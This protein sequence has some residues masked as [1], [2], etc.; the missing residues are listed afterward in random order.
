MSRGADG[1]DD[2]IGYEVEDDGTDECFFFDAKTA[3]EEEDVSKGGGGMSRNSGHGGGLSNSRHSS[4]GGG[5][6]GLSLSRHSSH[7]SDHPHH[8]AEDDEETAATADPDEEHHPDDSFSNDDNYPFSVGDVTCWKAV[9]APHDVF[10]LT[11]GW[12]R[13]NKSQIL[14]GLTVALAQIPEAVS[15]SFVAGVDPI[16]GLQVRK[17]RLYLVAVVGLLLVT[18][19]KRL[20]LPLSIAGMLLLIS[21]VGMASRAPGSWV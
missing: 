7:Y 15:F 16:V 9:R 10:T 17:E 13:H 20:P 8:L 12:L 5:G 14:S 21:Y 6:G 19:S 18:Q 11:W 4:K 2:G 1:K 3:N